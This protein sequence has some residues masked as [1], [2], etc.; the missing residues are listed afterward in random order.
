VIS[1]RSRTPKERR[2]VQEG[3]LWKPRGAKWSPEPGDGYVVVE[4][5]DEGTLV[6][7]VTSWPRLDGLGRLAFPHES[8]TFA[9]PED[10]LAEALGAEHQRGS[11]QRFR[12]GDTFRVPGLLVNR[13]A[14]ESADA[15]EWGEFVDVTAQARDAA[16]TALY[17]AAAPLVHDQRHAEAIGLVEG[18]G[19][20]PPSPRSAPS[21]GPSV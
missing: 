8:S 12:V 21:V 15:L 11:A 9:V 2:A 14:P 6:L 1:Q 17:A 16:K 7:L 10:R 18:E 5:Q 20:L 3:K 4:D 19:E 13:D